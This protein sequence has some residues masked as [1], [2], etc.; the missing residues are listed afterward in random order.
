[1]SLT[2]IA[3]LPEFRRNG[4]ATTV[5]QRLQEEAARTGRDVELSVERMNENAFQLYRDL[6]FEVTGESQVHLSMRWSP[7]TKKRT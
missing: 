1:L 3:V 2:D 6:G 4:I 5:I 7:T